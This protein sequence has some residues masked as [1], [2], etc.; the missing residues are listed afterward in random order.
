M[1]F[2]LSQIYYFST[3]HHLVKHFREENSLAMSNFAVFLEHY[4]NDL[5]V[6]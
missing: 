4:F 6:I 1:F 5:C 2:L 3:L